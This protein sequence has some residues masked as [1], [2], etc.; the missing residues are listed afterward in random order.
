MYGW[1]TPRQLGR[2]SERT[3]RRISASTHVR[4]CGDSYTSRGRRTML[5]FSCD[6]LLRF[7]RKVV[8]SWRQYLASPRQS[9]AS[10][11]QNAAWGSKMLPLGNKFLLWE[12]KSCLREA[13]F[14]LR[15]A[16][17]CLRDANL[18]SQA[19]ED[20]DILQRPLEALRRRRPPHSARARR[21]PLRLRAHLGS[22]LPTG[23][24]PVRALSAPYSCKGLIAF[25]FFPLFLL[26]IWIFE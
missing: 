21:P 13:T 16:K 18:K 23:R 22:R 24:V 15:G 25:S 6:F 26:E 5:S 10:G 20:I 12:P 17:F 14:C 4:A 1:R 9:F 8:V 11:K 7:P 19:N 3:P 2:T